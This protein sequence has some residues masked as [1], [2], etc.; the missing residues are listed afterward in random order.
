VDLRI[1]V[2]AKADAGELWT[3]Q[4]AAYVSEAIAYDAARI[5]PLTETLDELTA[6]I[7]DGAPTG[8]GT[9]I[10]K[11]TAGHRL[12]GTVSGRLRDGTCHVGRLAVVPDLQGRGIGSRLLTELEA[13]MSRATRFELFTGGRSEANIKLYRRLGYTEFDRRPDPVGVPLVYLEKAQTSYN[14]RPDSGS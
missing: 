6:R 7:S 3:L 2:A 12:V 8:G 1:D 10:L 5:P 11:A 9:L 13:R 14:S 4:R